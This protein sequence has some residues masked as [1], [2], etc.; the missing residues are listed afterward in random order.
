ME[1][2]EDWTQPIRERLKEADGP[3]HIGHMHKGVDRA[4]V[5]SAAGY[6]V[7]EDTPYYRFLV[8][9]P[10]DIVNLL[11]ARE[12]LREALKFYSNDGNQ[13]DLCAP[14]Q[15]S[16]FDGETWNSFGTVAKKALAWEPEEDA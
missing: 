16:E 6:I 3:W 4:D 1:T 11:K 12:V 7:A 10:T 2:F 9:C 14:S 13:I 8:R 5:D 15:E